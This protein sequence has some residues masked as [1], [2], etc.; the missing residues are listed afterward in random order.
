MGWY[1]CS[2]VAGTAFALIVIVGQAA[3]RRSLSL[4]AIWIARIFAAV[5]WLAGA[6]NALSLPG[7]NLVHVAGAGT[8]LA[9]SLPVLGAAWLATALVTSGFAAE[10]VGPL[11]IWRLVT[12]YS[13][14]L[15]SYA[16]PWRSR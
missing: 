14:E 12:A 7:E 3:L 10:G 4:Q 11:R 9:G 5:G 2:I 6:V 16:W 1:F 15:G 13:I 8:A